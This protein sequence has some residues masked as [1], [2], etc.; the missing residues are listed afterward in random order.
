[1]PWYDYHVY[2]PPGSDFRGHGGGTN[3]FSTFT[4]FDIKKRRG[5]VVLSNANSNCSSAIGW[6]ILQG[7]SLK[8]LNTTEAQPVTEI[9]GIGA[10]LAI[11][12][13]SKSLQI[14]KVVPKSPAAEA[15]LANGLI[16]EQIDGVPTA[17]MSTEAGR[18]LIGGA[19]GSKVLL[20]VI[21]PKNKIPRTVEV[22]RKK[23]LLS[24]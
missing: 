16:I 9:I 17:G 15:G 13:D 4:G 19:A 1:M 18:R 2:Q 3:G 12:T 22:T 20:V 24:S 7:A 11:D 14:S 5:V 10:A 6:R 8:D 21:D 23:I